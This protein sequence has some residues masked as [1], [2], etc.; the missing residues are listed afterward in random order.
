MNKKLLLCSVVCS[1]IAAQSRAADDV[2]IDLSVLDEVPQ[3]SIG[4]VHFSPAFPEVKK[5]VIQPR[6]NTAPVAKKVQKK[7]EKPIVEIQPVKPQI[8][9]NSEDDL[10]TKEQTEEISFDMPAE[11][12]ETDIET[13]SQENI[14]H[15]EKELSSGAEET[16]SSYNTEKREQSSET[17]ENKLPEVA[18]EQAVSSEESLDT[19]SESTN[20]I[21]EPV[22]ILPQPLEQPEK[23]VQSGEE[24]VLSAEVSDEKENSQTIQIMPREVYS[25]SFAPDSSDLSED[26]MHYL[27]EVMSKFDKDQKKKISIKAY[28]YDNGED[29]FRKKRISLVRATQ[30]RSYLLNH[31][32]KNFSIKIINTTADSDDRN[33]V[34]IEELN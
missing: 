22:S 30:V 33:S 20:D 17:E 28:N 29:S 12:S 2:Y 15:E 13:T 10:L 21:G 27:D 24:K 14:I 16:E 7:V 11:N 31:G 32:F 18:N 3:D 6:Q 23:E 4:F 34:E 25:L 8:A 26:N 5:V 1:L 9:E 19:S